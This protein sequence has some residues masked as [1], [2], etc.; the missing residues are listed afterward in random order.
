MSKFLLFSSSMLVLIGA[1]VSFAQSPPPIPPNVRINQGNG[2]TPPPSNVP[3]P[4]IGPPDMGL[5]PEMAND[6]ANFPQGGVPPANSPAASPEPSDSATL[7]FQNPEGYNYDPT[8]RR[9][10][11]KPYGESQSIQAAP[12]S[13]D[14]E[15]PKVVVEPLQAYD[16]S[17]FK[18]L[19]II[20]QVKDPKAMVL[21]PAG[22]THLIRKQTKIGRNNGFVAAIRE[23]EVIVVEPTVAENGAPTALTRVMNLTK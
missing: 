23:G 20:W 14:P 2:Q 5:P 17:E 9:D 16:I 21:D 7:Q 13:R 3:P 6:P 11:F 10:P 8:G 4:E 18:L 19:G 1:L 15:E 12:V 22:K